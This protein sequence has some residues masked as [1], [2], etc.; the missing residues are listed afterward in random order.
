[1]ERKTYILIGVILVVVIAIIYLE[2]IKP[3]ITNNNSSNNLGGNNLLTN[4]Q[5][6]KAPELAGISGYINADS[7]LTI[8]SLRGKSLL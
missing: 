4:S 5:Y 7:N 3:Q 2:S 1:M 8:E 6:L